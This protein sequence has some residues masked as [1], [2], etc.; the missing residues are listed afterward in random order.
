[1]NAYHNSHAP[2]YRQPFGAVSAGETVTLTLDVTASSDTVSCAL[3]LKQE[4]QAAQT[5]PMLP[6][7]GGPDHFSVTI[8]TPA[9]GTLLWYFFAL[10]DGRGPLQYYG[11]N[12]GGF[13]GSGQ[14]SGSEPPPYQITVYEKSSAPEWYKNAIVYQIFPD[15]FHRGRDWETRRSNSRRPGSWRGPT[16]VFQENWLDTPFYTKNEQGAVTRWPFFGGTLEGI[17]E[18]LLYLK[19]LGVSAIYLNPIFE[20]A[21]NH[22]YDTADYT[23]IDPGFGDSQSFSA[24]VQAAE[25]FG[26]G[27][28][29][30]G[31]FSHTGADSI[32]FNKY[33]NYPG[34][35]AFQGASSPFFDWYHF[36]RFPE[37]YDSWWGVDDLPKADK[38]NAA[39]GEFIFGGADSVIRR[40]LRLGARG[41][42]L[43][44]ADELPD[45][46][47]QGIR[48]AMTAQRP[49]SIL[50]G[51]VWEDAS[52]KI[53][54]GSRRRYLLGSGLQSVTNYPFRLAGMDYMLGKCSAFALADRLMSLKENY[55]P[56]SS[57][58]ALNLIGSHDRVRAITLL[59]DAPEALTDLQKEY[60]KLSDA[61]YAL[62][63]QRLKLLSLLQFAVSG[64][65]C[66]YYGD[67]AGVQGYEDPYNR[68]PYPWG[69]EDAELLE[70]YR[71]LAMLR[72]QYKPFLCGDFLP[73][74]LTEH[75][76]SVRRRTA[77]EELLVL[78]NRGVF[79]W[80]TVTLQTG[81]AYILDLLQSEEL[82]PA[83]GCLTFTMPP[84]TARVLFLQP[85]PP[86]TAELTRAAGV[87]CHISSIPTAQTDTAS[88][89]EIYQFIDFLADSGQKLWQLLPLNP[90]GKGNS[91]FFTPSVF[92]LG[93]YISDSA[94]AINNEDFRRFCA[95]NAYWL[96]DYALYLS[97]KAANGGKPWQEWPEGE[98]RRCDIE[99]LLALHSGSIWS[100]K[101]EQ[102]RWQLNWQSVKKYANSH[103]ITI[104]GDIPVYTA[105]DSADVWAHQGLFRLD[106]TG[107]AALH[108]GVPPDYF[109]LR[110]QDW[111]NPLYAWDSAKE[112]VYQ[113]WEN[114]LRR[115]M[116][117]YDIIRI[118]HFRS[119]SAY[120]AIQ[121]G[122]QPV[123]GCWLSGAGI[124]FFKEMRARLGSLPFIAEDLGVLDAG[125]RNLLKLTGLPGMN[126]WQFCAE[127]MQNAA[128]E[129]AARRVF[130]SGTHDNQT[131]V[132]W[133]ADTCPD[134][135]PVTAAGEIIEK[136]YATN[137]PW[138]ITPLQ[139]LLL[140]GDE[141]RMNTPGIVGGNWQWQAQRAQ[142]TGALSA[143][144]RELCKENR[145]L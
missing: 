84:L 80:E 94:A 120:F 5:I 35:G 67:E 121:Q 79:E 49:D 145:R 55:P 29:L 54:Y 58:M 141:A 62:A 30:D 68:A 23:K 98:K 34:S 40:W 48:S 115:A 99:A 110:G 107:C 106:E 90:R 10:R 51:E 77:E 16:R 66:I 52:S 83:G 85:E 112:G 73:Q 44:V 123:D 20:A 128:P 82:H 105:P 17:R 109:S 125:V 89:Q 2:Q 143:K 1:M 57:A 133:C 104:I 4:G 142:I 76:L 39:Y 56:D 126:V 64:V 136:L 71:T 31:V 18:K 46:F 8:Q 63:K 92:A 24:L 15:R 137:A 78:V 13:G 129:D 42:R 119:F 87:L 131:L 53:S 140:L 114:R 7:D 139:D 118:D 50:L 43:D 33:G 102:Y 97:L 25:E 122:T 9:Q 134:Q 69:A 101:Q 93:S 14:L 22:K 19:S 28:I 41:W 72:L 3:I 75:V 11:N 37:Q 144:L 74:G 103:G 111:G 86:V 96:E 124:D 59:G 100:H 27:L 132:G 65:P 61:Q 26:I 45:A 95:E 116:L 12:P 135:N 36:D 38:Q 91:P 138:V 32:Y 81:G 130:Y 88:L 113:F 60:F 108:A 117:N 70:H 127:E 47:I 21:S 6:S